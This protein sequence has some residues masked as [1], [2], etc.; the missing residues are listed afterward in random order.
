MHVSQIELMHINEITFIL[1]FKT[2]KIVREFESLGRQARKMLQT[3][4]PQSSIDRVYHKMI[5]LIKSLGAI[6]VLVRKQYPQ[7]EKLFDALLEM[8]KLG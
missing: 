5:E 6:E 3:K 4:V 8:N 7:Y 1:E 2:E